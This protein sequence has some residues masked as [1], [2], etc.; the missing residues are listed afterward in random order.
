MII[1]I[2]YECLF[3]C[4]N[5]MEGCYMA[6]VKGCGEEVPEY[7]KLIIDE[8]DLNFCRDKSEM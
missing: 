7:S 2:L 8:N 3:L 1:L 6:A 4:I 5:A